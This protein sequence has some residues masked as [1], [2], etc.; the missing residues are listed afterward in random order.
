MLTADLPDARLTTDTPSV[1]ALTLKA[2][3]FTFRTLPVEIGELSETMSLA[4]KR[5]LH[6]SA[7]GAELMFETVNTVPFGAEPEIHR[8][9]KISQ[10]LA[11]VTQDLVM[12]ASCQLTSVSAG[13]F[14]I[15]GPIRKFALVMPP[16]KGCSPEFP[17]KKDFAS[18]EE[19][20]IV[21]DAPYPPLALLLESEKQRFDWLVGDDYWRWTNAERIGGGSARFVITREKDS[22]RM[23]WKIFEKKPVRGGEEEIPIPGRNWRL[24]WAIAWKALA[25]PRRKKAA[26]TFDMAGTVWDDNAKAVAGRKK[27][28]PSGRGCFCASATLNTLKK[29]LRTEPESLREGTILEITNVAPVYCVNAGHVDRAKYDSLPHGDRMSVIEFRRWANRALSAKE[30]SL[31]ITAPARSPWRGFA[32]LD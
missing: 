7:D 25:L 5:R 22:L 23:Q 31:R 21:Y 15:S 26:R 27:N 12:R 13:G 32:V 10:G 2:D 9:V 11:A 29:W 24:T 17:E 6:E 19:K 28:A 3:D 16:S 20:S 4:S 18:L 8:K 1:D 30:C 14:V